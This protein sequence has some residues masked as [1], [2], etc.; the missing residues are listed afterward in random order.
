M[1]TNCINT[2]R[3]IKCN[4]LRSLTKLSVKNWGCLQKKTHTCTNAEM[5]LGLRLFFYYLFY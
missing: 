3:E 1:D 2:K 4:D 5:H